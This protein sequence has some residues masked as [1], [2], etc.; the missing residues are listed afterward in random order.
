MVAN[1]I[2]L[3]CASPIANKRQRGKIC[4]I[5]FRN[6]WGEPAS[7]VMTRDDGEKRGSYSLRT[8]HVYRK[9]R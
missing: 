4:A 1:M 3:K 2:W 5:A 9:T 6:S 7:A 8:A